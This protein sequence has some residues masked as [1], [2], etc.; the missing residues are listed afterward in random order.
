MRQRPFHLMAKPSASLCNIQ[1]EYCFYLEKPH[2]KQI[3]MHDEILEKYIKQYIQSAPQSEITFIWQGGE[4]TL[5]GL[6]FFQ[7]AV[8]LQQ[9]YADKKIIRNSLQTNGILLNDAWCRFFKAHDFLIGI[10]LDGTQPM[11]DVYRKNGRGKGTWKQVKSAVDLLQKHQVTFNILTVVHNQNADC[12]REL[13]LFLKSLGVNYMQFIPLMAAPEQQASANAYGQ[14]LI[15]VFDC[16]Y[17]QDIGRISVQF[18]EQ[19]LMAFFGYQPSLCIFRPTCGDQMIIEQNGDIYSCDHYVYP[20]YKI[21]NIIET[22]LIQIT[23]ST[24]QQKFGLAKQHLSQKCRQ[25]E[26]LFACHGGCPK[27]RTL[28]SET[29]YPH[30]YLCEAY[31]MALR[32]MAPY[33]KKLARKFG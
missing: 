18:I 28:L 21:G 22:P 6:D 9:R 3:K 15:D 10:S 26:F 30:N 20:Q 17:Q 33:L 16:W 11:H 2:Q 23:D 7:R 1:C 13:Y 32:H 8:A 5:C 29:D 25:C 27:H 19:W 12:G 14:F 24:Q 4:P 31:Y